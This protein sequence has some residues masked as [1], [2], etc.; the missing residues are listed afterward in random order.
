M[1][2]ELIRKRVIEVLD[3]EG[4][5]YKG[6]LNH[7]NIDAVSK[8]TEYVWVMVI[9]IWNLDSSQCTH[10]YITTMI[11]EVFEIYSDGGAE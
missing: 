6:L 3:F 7:H 8:I 2:K 5:D 4:Y 11:Y 10:S 9:K 1:N